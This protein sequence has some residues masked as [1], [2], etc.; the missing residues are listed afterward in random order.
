MS[1]PLGSLETLCSDGK[2][3]EGSKANE[4]QHA[5]EHGGSLQFRGL[6]KSKKMSPR[7][8]EDEQKEHL[9]KIA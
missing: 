2:Y 1:C 6:P 5:H 4:E 9:A 8:Q 7:M 3:C